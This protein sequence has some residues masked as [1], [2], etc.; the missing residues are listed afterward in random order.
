MSKNLKKKLNNGHRIKMM[1]LAFERFQ[2][3][4]G[5]EKILKARA[6]LARKIVDTSAAI[7]VDEMTVL[8]KHGAVRPLDM[9]WLTSSM[10][11]PIGSKSFT[12]PNG[13][14]V[15]RT[16]DDTFH[17]MNMEVPKIDKWSDLKRTLSGRFFHEFISSSDM[18]VKF[19]RI[20]APGVS[21]RHIGQASYFENVNEEGIYKDNLGAW[22]EPVMDTVRDYYRLNEQVRQTETTLHTAIA[23]LIGAAETFGDVVAVWPEVLEIEMA[24]FGEHVPARNALIALNDNDRAAICNHLGR[25]GIT[26]AACGELTSPAYIEAAE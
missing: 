8:H 5:R 1:N 3:F 25:R 21:R 4:E 7:P 24:L 19:E 11:L 6:D 2:D 16:D 17:L 13:E 15:Q 26:S 20:E 10:K 14:A 18:L 12:L 9:I 23:K 22:F